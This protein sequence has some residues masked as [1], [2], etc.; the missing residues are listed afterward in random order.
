MDKS[1]S[2]G[3]PSAGD[4]DR[5]V[6]DIEDVEELSADDGGAED[7]AEPEAGPEEEPRSSGAEGRVTYIRD[8]ERRLAESQATLGE[9]IS[10]YKRLE[11]DK[12]E[13]KR[14]LERE[15]DKELGILRGKLVGDMMELMDN[16]DRSVMGSQGS[17]NYDALAQGL[18]MVLV[19]FE[20]KLARLGVERVP[21]IGQAFDPNF[22]EALDVAAT[23]NPDEDG[24]VLVEYS[25]G[26]KLDDRVI[27]PAR[28]R[29]GRLV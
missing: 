6:V 12:E 17:R 18:K 15:K 2:R 11:Q 23:A 16:L 28:V 19:Q 29:V 20:E 25:R 8:L 24:V 27:R 9:Y 13:F 26:F 1:E 5:E 22:H 14:R 7:D 4:G 21:T 3:R 10:A